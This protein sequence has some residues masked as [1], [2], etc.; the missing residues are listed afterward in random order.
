MTLAKCYPPTPLSLNLS[1]PVMCSG[2]QRSR[3]HAWRWSGVIKGQLSSINAVRLQLRLFTASFELEVLLQEEGREQQKKISL[4]LSFLSTECHLLKMGAILLLC[5]VLLCT[6][7]L[8]VSTMGARS[9]QH[10]GPSVGVALRNASVTVRG[11]Y[12]LYML[13]LY[14][15]LRVAEHNVFIQSSSWHSSDSVLSL[16]ATGE[17]VFL[18][19]SFFKGYF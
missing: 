3:S 16:T 5:T 18:L 1:A 12:P 17:S 10:V 4:W 2:D 13:Q 6:A 14:R 9:G 19:F 7:S 8:A 11:R 15:S